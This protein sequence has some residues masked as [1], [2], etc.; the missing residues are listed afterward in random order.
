MSG[1]FVTEDNPKSTQHLVVGLVGFPYELVIG[2]RKRC[3]RYAIFTS[4][5][6]SGFSRIPTT[7]GWGSCD[8][9]GVFR[10]WSSTG[11]EVERVF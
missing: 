10:S 6:I 9:E 11:R 7:A 1:V 5:D 2:N 4:L 8:R 3:G